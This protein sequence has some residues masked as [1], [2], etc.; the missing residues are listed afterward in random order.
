MLPSQARIGLHLNRASISLAPSVHLRFR[1][2]IT[3][4]SMSAKDLNNQTSKDSQTFTLPDGRALGFSEYGHP[5]GF[6]IVF[7]HGWPSSR[8]EGY[9][10]DK[11]A[12]GRGVRFLCL[13]RPGFGISTFQPHRRITDYP[14]D[15]A[16]FAR[17]LELKRFA[18]LG[19]SGGGPYALACAK[20]L[21]REMLSAVGVCAGAPPWVAGI[22]D[23]PWLS[24]ITAA[25]AKTFPNV[26]RVLSDVLIGTLRW[27]MTS[28][29]VTRRLDR[30]LEKKTEEK[31]AKGKEE[32][33]PLLAEAVEVE[34]E[35]PTEVRRAQLLGL[36]F[37]GFAQGSAAFVQEAELLTSDWGFKFEDVSYDTIQ[38][39][40]GDKDYQ[41]PIGMIRYMAEHLPHARLHEYAGV[42]HYA[43]GY[44][45]E[46]ILSELV[47]EETIAKHRGEK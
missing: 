19:A 42:N 33:A 43:M 35:K 29:P 28:G 24:R 20:A 21:P 36:V 14:A 37:E 9:A 4:A 47:P 39:W 6:P 15:V 11:L 8:L 30:W 16:A 38:I 40:H 22:R 10:V 18:V 7:F 41:A 23:V 2:A 34:E 1:R 12:R 17:H 46:E 25:T 26:L 31:K 44:K 3:A 13:E 45:L 32:G 5:T 27:I